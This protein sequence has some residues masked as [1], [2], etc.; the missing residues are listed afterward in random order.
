[1]DLAARGTGGDLLTRTTL[2]FGSNP[3]PSAIE[4]V[5]RALRRVPGVLTVETDAGASN[6]LVAHDAGVPTA[7]LLAAAKLAGVEV[8][9]VPDV[10]ARLALAAPVTI[11][12]PLNQRHLRSVAIA[13]ILGV[14]IIDMTFPHSPDK[15][16]V[17]LIPLA[18]VW[19]IIVVG[20]L[21][22][23]RQ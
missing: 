14:I 15:R 5:V 16:W 23:R 4:Q 3:S 12:Q 9:V 13:A 10:C 22:A 11:A 17:Y 21:A 18:M 20:S 2:R 6:A 8:K 7:S 1:M 19:A